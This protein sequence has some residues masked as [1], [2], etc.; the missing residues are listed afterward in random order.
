MGEALQIRDVCGDG[1]GVA[2]DGRA[3]DALFVPQSEVMAG[4]DAVIESAR[5]RQAS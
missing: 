2:S 4:L 5:Q 1:A 3:P